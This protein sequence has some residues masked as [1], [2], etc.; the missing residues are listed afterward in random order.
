MQRRD[1]KWIEEADWSKINLADYPALNGCVQNSLICNPK[2]GETINIGKDDKSFVVK[3]YAHGN[4]EK[5]T[6]IT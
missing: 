3:G 4:G 1:Y 2:D 5:G 6:K